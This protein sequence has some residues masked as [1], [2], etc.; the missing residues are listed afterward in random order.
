[1][2]SAILDVENRASTQPRTLVDSAQV[3]ALIQSESLEEEI[4]LY[5]ELI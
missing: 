4:E 3:T 1:M 5:S 2:A